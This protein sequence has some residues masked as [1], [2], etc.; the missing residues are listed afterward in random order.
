MAPF[1]QPFYLMLNVAVGG[2]NGE[3]AG[4]YFP[5]EG[6]NAKDG[7]PKPWKKG[8]YDYDAFMKNTHAWLPT[9]VEKEHIA[10]AV[11]CGLGSA[12]EGCMP[13]NT[14]LPLTD[15]S[16]PGAAATLKDWYGP[17]NYRTAARTLFLRPYLAH[18]CPVF[19]RFFVVFSV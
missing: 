10:W 8:D 13:S 9:W 15:L 12:F 17:L 11:H 6:C 2:A 3:E 18:F 16:T 19:S 7:S 14:T 5:A 4:G 1:D